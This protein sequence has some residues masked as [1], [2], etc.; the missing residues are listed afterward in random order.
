MQ[1]FH[2]QCIRQIISRTHVSHTSDPQKL[3][4]KA[5]HE[6]HEGGDEKNYAQH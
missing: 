3:V 2:P 5:F 1:D 6:E 4:A